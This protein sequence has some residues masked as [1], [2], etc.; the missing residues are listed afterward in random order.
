MDIQ[1]HFY[2]HSAILAAAAGQ[3][4]VRHFPGLL[5]HGWPASS[6]VASMFHDFPK[7]GTDASKRKLLVWSHESRAWDPA[8][9]RH[10]TIPIGA[11]FLYLL[12][13]RAGDQTQIP[14]R[15]RRPLIAPQHTTVLRGAVGGVEELAG[16]YRDKFGPSTVCLHG[17]D[18]KEPATVTAWRAAGHDVVTAGGRFD[19]RGL[20]RQLTGLRSASCLV[21]DRLSTFVFYALAAG[22]PVKIEGATTLLEGDTSVTMDSL[23]E[24]WPE[25]H[26]PTAPLA[27]QQEVALRELGSR[28]LLD[29]AELATTI[30]WDHFG[31]AAASGLDYWALSPFRKAAMVLGITQRT[32]FEDNARKVGTDQKRPAEASSFLKHPLS[33]L[34]SRLPELPDM[35]QPVDWLRPEDV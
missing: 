20:S 25:V 28:Y 27:L 34:P 14:E 9:E 21:T 17:D 22:V 32:E 15:E 10:R 33:H 7:V 5:Q 29:E 24:R 35:A 1:N 4:R 26:D 6:P 18:L 13:L 3:P 2:G 30:G 19:P 23:R 12:R 8:A 16:Y 11:P 31:A